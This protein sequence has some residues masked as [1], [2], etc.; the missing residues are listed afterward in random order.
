[1]YINVKIVEPFLGHVHPGLLIDGLD[2]MSFLL[3]ALDELVGGVHRTEGELCHHD[4]VL[5]LLVTEDPI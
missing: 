4:L 2:G 5:R 3:E 1:M